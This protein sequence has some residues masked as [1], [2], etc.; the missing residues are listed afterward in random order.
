M[1]INHRI[2]EHV[3]RYLVG[4][5]YDGSDMQCAKVCYAVESVV[6]DLQKDLILLVIFSVTGLFQEFLFCF[7]TVNLV[8][9]YLGGIH[10]KTNVGCTL[11]SIGVYVVAVTGGTLVPLPQAVTVGIILLT[12][13]LMWKVAPLPS[14]N[15]PV[16][17]GERKRKIQRR[18]MLGLGILGICTVLYPFGSAFIAWTLILQIVEVGVVL[19]RENYLNYE[20]M[21]APPS[22]SE[23]AEKLFMEY[24]RNYE[25]RMNG[26]LRFP[27]EFG[28]MTRKERTSAF[29]GFTDQEKDAVM[30]LL[31]EK[32][33]ERLVQ[34]IHYQAVHD[35]W[36]RR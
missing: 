12:V 35:F 18:G 11:I 26:L 25:Q 6:G 17:R 36:R 24:T 23:E 32:Q 7:L 29:K 28:S 34:D 8:R 1:N 3:T 30:S 5:D 4:R 33:K 19:V 14:P 20:N 13:Y 27:A 9:R 2:G 22:I 16:Y 15:R 31:T 21:D 10:M